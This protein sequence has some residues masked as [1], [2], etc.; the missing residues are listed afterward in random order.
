MADAEAKGNC[1]SVN[2][3]LCSEGYGVCPGAL[4]PSLCP[5]WPRGCAVAAALAGS[6]SFHLHPRWLGEAENV[7]LFW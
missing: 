2:A 7:Q 5:P 6:T 3:G 4:P 1:L